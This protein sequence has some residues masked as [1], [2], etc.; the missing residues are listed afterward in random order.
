MHLRLR[1]DSSVASAKMRFS[2]SYIWHSAR[3][4]PRTG[5]DTGGILTCPA[6]PR[7]LHT[8]QTKLSS[9][10]QVT[11]PPGHQGGDW[12]PKSLHLGLLPLPCRA[13]TA[14]L[15]GMNEA[16]R[17]ISGDVRR[18]LIFPAS[19]ILHGGSAKRPCK[20]RTISTPF[21]LSGAAQ[22]PASHCRPSIYRLSHFL[23]VSF[24]PSLR[25]GALGA[26]RRVVWSFAS[27]YSAGRLGAFAQR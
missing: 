19:R 14:N 18:Y 4:V 20:S 13:F 17:F 1:G 23:F 27:H 21:S 7:A 5:K 12:P 16:G 15:G 26:G 11:F 9:G 2:Y 6:L 8:G 22:R 3:R 24:L 25:P 10:I